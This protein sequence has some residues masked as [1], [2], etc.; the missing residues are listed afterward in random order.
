MTAPPAL[1]GTREH[2]LSCNAEQRPART[3]RSGSAR[4]A[5]RTPHLAPLRTAP[6]LPHCFAPRS[7]VRLKRAAWGG[8]LYTPAA[9]HP[10]HPLA[11]SPPAMHA[12]KCS[13][14]AACPRRS[15]AVGELQLP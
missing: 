4:C 8:A 1:K 2:P 14:R 5:H 3:D 12:G 13:P 6:L 11:P 7:Q 15:R 10:S 9:A